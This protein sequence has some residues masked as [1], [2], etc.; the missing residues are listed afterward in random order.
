MKYAASPP[1]VFHT[2]IR[3]GLRLTKLAADAGVAKMMRRNDADVDKYVGKLAYDNLKDM[4]P[5]FVKIGQFMSTRS[6]IFGKD[7]TNELKRL[8]DNV[9][10]MTS[11]D[12]APM[13]AKLKDNFDII[14][15]TPLAAASIG[16]VHYGKLKDGR[17]VAIK[18][19]RRNIDTIIKSDFGML[20]GVINFIKV[21]A[22]HRQITEVEISLR[23]YFSLLQEEI[24]FANEVNNMKEFKNQFAGT[25]W[26]KVP[27]PYEE[28]CCQDIIVME[29]VPSV[30]V[31][32]IDKLRSMKLNSSLIAE[33]M[34]QC[35][36]T[37]VVQYG[38]VHI[39]PHPGNVGLTST[40]KVV[41]YDYG[42]FV[43]LDGVM[44]DSLKTLF[45]AM[46]DRD[47]E[48]VCD[49][50]IDLKIIIVDP[51]KKAYFKK[52][53]ASFLSYLDN[54]DLD[55]FKLSY[56]DKIDQS[57]MQFLITSK[58][59]LVLRGISILEGICK[60]L[61]PNFNY[62]EVL[63]PFINEFILDISYLERRG[64]K[65]FA[66]FT[67]ASDKITTSEITIGMVEKDMDTLKKKL[68]LA[69]TKVKYT[70]LAMIM[71]LGV[72][73]DTPIAHIILGSA[74]LYVL[75]NRNG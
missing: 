70:S 8:Q 49:I 41:F 75:F 26:I 73:A 52:F 50:L 30:K 12:L 51:S 15:E 13:I 57:E 1:A 10:P 19:K 38:F 20:L 16:Q 18:F 39:D 47:V 29:Y 2:Q 14:N 60:Q 66:R 4:G 17:E 55:N 54:L 25:S 7:F 6:D 59:I 28:Y 56:L 5:T 62:R 63:D 48:D 32:D 33:K 3:K 35:F 68:V 72:Q 22:S 21:F 69:D 43:K 11:E 61:N 34:L 58:F 64:S 44:K 37:Q 45:L 46:Y 27:T 24:N 53:I 40:G 9:T 65:D 42:M 36:F 23:E 67:K 71:A 74:F 31:D